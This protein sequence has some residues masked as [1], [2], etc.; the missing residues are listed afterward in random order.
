[1]IQRILRD[2]L[3]LTEA[4]GAGANVND[5]VDPGVRDKVGW[6]LAELQDRQAAY[7]WEITVP[8]DGT[9]LP[10]HFAGARLEPGYLVVAARS[11]TGLARLNEE[12]M[13]INNEQANVLRTTARDL[14]VAVRERTERDDAV[15]EQ[16][17]RLNNEMANL[18]RE[19][20]RKNAELERL[21]QQKNRLLGMAAHDLRNP[22][23]VILNY[24]DFLEESAAAALND[25][26]R[27]FLTAIKETSRFMLRLV[28]DLLDVTTIESGQLTLDRHPTDLARLIQ[29]NV[30]LNRT[31]AARKDIALEFDPPAVAPELD[32]DAGKVEQVLN[33]LISNAVKYSH[34]GTRVRVRLDC[35]T[36]EATVAVQDEGQGIPAADLAK[37]FRPFSK[38]SV[39]TTGGEE[40]TGL[41]L[42]I[43]RRMVEGHGGRVWVDSKVGTGSTFYFTLPA[44]PGARPGG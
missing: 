3:G 24:S 30:A 20:A 4:V 33:N 32:I 40:S 29:R 8:L 36:Q 34:R 18:Q 9:L 23:G 25:E 7:D 43:A 31:L 19:L 38:A 28:N 5:L 37:L 21:D 13:R 39:R 27:E 2:D 42:A 15:Y 41:G 10:L 14:S 35:A 44:A 22:L 11:R 12:M 1:M 17:S 26:Q 6:F 16:L